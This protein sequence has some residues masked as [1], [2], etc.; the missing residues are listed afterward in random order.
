MQTVPELTHRDRKKGF[1]MERTPLKYRTLPAY[2][3]GEER[4][5]MITHIVGGGFAVVAATLSIL[6]AALHRSPYAVVSASVYG[7]SLIFLYT[8]SSIYHGL[9]PRLMGKRVF[10]V[11]DHCA[12][13][14]LIA[15]TYTPYC[16]CTLREVS[17]AL[18]WTYFGVV[19]GLTALAVTFN[20]IDLKKYA[21]LSNLATLLLG[22]CIIFRFGVVRSSI[23]EVGSALLFFGGV[24]YTVGCLTYLI[25][26]KRRFFHG[27][28]HLFVLLGSILQFFSIFFFV[29]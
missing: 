10:Q 24:A 2:S 27:I 22:W 17:P 25:G 14:V 26:A 15:G 6:L 8:M 12:V 20:A 5:H 4:F 7:V 18:G 11:M 1:P 28:F 9:S 3:R 16:L 23:G 21:V 29:L 13:Y 19:W